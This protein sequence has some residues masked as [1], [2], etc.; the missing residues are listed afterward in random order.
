LSVKLTDRFAG[1]NRNGIRT[2]NGLDFSIKLLLPAR[3]GKPEVALPMIQS[4]DCTRA[5][6][7]T[8]C[9]AINYGCYQ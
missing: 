5:L 8:C 1:S 4:T 6:L 3:V 7:P 9:I 2:G